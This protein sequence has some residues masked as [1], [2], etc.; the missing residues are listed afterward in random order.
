MSPLQT[1]PNVLGQLLDPVGRLM[2]LEFA[3][4]LA[5]LRATPEMQEHIDELAEK[6]SEGTMTA[7]ERAEYEAIVDAIDVLGVLQAKAR[8]VIARHRVG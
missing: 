4:G 5:D 8:E 2:P 3:R 7:E 1:A 6:C